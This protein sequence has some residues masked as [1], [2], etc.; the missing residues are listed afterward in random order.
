MANLYKKY[1]KSDIEFADGGYKPLIYFA[2]VETFLSIK[3][4]TASP[5]LLGDLKKITTAHTFTS[6]AGWI[7][8]L[9]K[10][11]SV[12]SKCTTVGED[13]ATRLQWTFEATF[14][15][16]K[17]E[18]LEQLEGMQLFNDAIFIIKDQDC[19]NATD[20]VQFG[21]EC[22]Q[23]ILKVDFDGKTTKEGLK[24]YKITGTITGKKFFYS[25]TLTEKT[26]A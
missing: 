3:N 20:F 19:I 5:T 24:E 21:D 9:C 14:L 12:T 8:M 25:G 2:P 16:D 26:Y 17:P 13:G 4:P 18:L 22:S 10:V 1:E 15:G 6:P 7:S 23:P 11:H